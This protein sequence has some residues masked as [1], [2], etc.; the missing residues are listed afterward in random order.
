MI[1]NLNMIAPSRR[2]GSFVETESVDYIMEKDGFLVR[3]F[4]DTG[5][6]A[7]YTEMQI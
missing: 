4:R 3:I 1:N 7:T 6:I 2:Y 5:L